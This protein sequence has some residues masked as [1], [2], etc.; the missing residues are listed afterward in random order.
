[1]KVRYYWIDWMKVIG[2][3]FIIWGHF[4][5]SY[6]T[7]I[8]YSFNVPLF[9][10]ISGYLGVGKKKLKPLLIPYLVICITYLFLDI[11]FQYKAG[12]L[13]LL[14]YA[15]SVGYML[16]GFQTTPH[17][18]NASA[19]WFVYTLALCKVLHYILQR[20]TYRGF[21]ALLCLL[22]AYATRN[23]HLFWSYQNV[24][25]CYPFYF[26]GA[27]LYEYGQS[28]IKKIMRLAKTKSL[29]CVL[30]ICLLVTTLSL[31]APSNG[32]VMM[33]QCG[34]GNNIILFLL[35]SIIGISIVF[36]LALLLECVRP[37]FLLIISQGNI[38][39]LAYHYL[40]IR[41]FNSICK[42]IS[43]DL[44]NNDLLT[45]C[46]SLIL[47]VVHIPIIKCVSRYFPIIMGGRKI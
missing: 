38:V 20:D 15:R 32:F 47:L 21:I 40:G 34:Y 13:S 11:P 30:L 27:L 29:L 23:S 45:F 33:Y 9:F 1:M 26:M 4:F 39:I 44:M 43:I 12:D 5:P 41:L 7:D 14:N 3:F 17:G 24:F 2:M 36:L 37:K 28:Q 22:F 18:V 10:C 35:L 19:M 46:M 8:I 31:A 16:L 42:M 6:F 25:I